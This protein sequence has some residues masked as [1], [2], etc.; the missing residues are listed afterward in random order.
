MDDNSPA[1]RIQE[2]DTLLLRRVET[3]SGDGPVSPNSGCATCSCLG[4]DIEVI[5]RVLRVVR[6]L[7]R[8]LGD[9]A[10]QP[11]YIINESRVGYRMPRPGEPPA[12]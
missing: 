1:L 3:A 5:G 2:G 4:E 10:R 11:T 6:R 9:D 7:R 12:H 8:K